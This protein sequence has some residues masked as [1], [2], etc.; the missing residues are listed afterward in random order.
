[1]TGREFRS[2]LGQF[3]TGV[4]LITVNDTLSGKLALTANSFSSVSLEPPLI[5]WS[6]QNSSDCY[7]EYTSCD[8]FG[9]SVLA[10]QHEDL[11]NRFAK[12]GG[13]SIDPALFTEDSQGTPR[14]SGALANFSCAMH[15]I[16]DAGDHQIIVG[17]V[18]DFAVNDGEPLL[19]H[20]GSY[21]RLLSKGALAS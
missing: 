8:F 4:C 7:R 17:R 16:L 1:M 13:H 3:A 5:L 14:L 19:F 20:G 9:V 15:N 6:I 10:S 18:V 21:D 11:S 2:A 12:K